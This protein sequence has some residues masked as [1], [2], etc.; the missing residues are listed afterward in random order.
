MPPLHV[1][2]SPFHHTNDVTRRQNTHPRILCPA[3]EQRLLTPPRRRLDLDVVC[4]IVGDVRYAVFEISLLAQLRGE[5]ALCVVVHDVRGLCAV[6]GFECGVVVAY[7]RFFTECAEPVG[8]GAE[9][10]E[11]KLAE[12]LDDLVGSDYRSV[13]QLNSCV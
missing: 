6:P 4:R 8:V 7:A 2:H 11:I 5:C 9:I 12:E 13:I 10:G 1:S 3:H